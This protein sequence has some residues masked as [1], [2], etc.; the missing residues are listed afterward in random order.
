MQQITQTK[1][2][3]DPTGTVFT[4]TLTNM[5][6]D[7]GVIQFRGTVVRTPYPPAS[8]DGSGSAVATNI[9]TLPAD[10]QPYATIAWTADVVT[11]AIATIQQQAI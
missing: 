5:V 7:A 8:R 9:T 11:A 2:E 10:V 6:D 4:E 1:Y 3:I